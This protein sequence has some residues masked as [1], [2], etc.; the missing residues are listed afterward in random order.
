[1]KNGMYVNAATRENMKM[2]VDDSSFVKRWAES[3]YGS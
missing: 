3:V 2:C 1:M